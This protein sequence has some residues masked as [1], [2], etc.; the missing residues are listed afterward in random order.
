MNSPG[1]RTEIIHSDPR[2]IR[3]P[4]IPIEAADRVCETDLR[5]LFWGS[6]NIRSIAT[7]PVRSPAGSPGNSNTDADEGPHQKKFDAEIVKA[8]QPLGDQVHFIQSSRTGKNA[9]DFH[10]AFSL[11]Q[12]HQ[13]NLTAKDAARYIVV[14]GDGGFESL[15]EHM[16]RLGCRVGKASSISE[17]CALAGKQQPESPPTPGLSGSVPSPLAAVAPAGKPPAP[18]VKGPPVPSAKAGTRSGT[19]AAAPSSKALRKT[20]AADDVTKVL[21]YMRT[22]AKNR[23]AKRNT[24]ERH[25]ISV[26]GNGV[27]VEVGRAV[28]DELERLNV[29]R[30]SGNKIEYTIPKTKK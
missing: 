10:I 28:V 19:S 24:L 26:L 3:R 1:A 27:T 30:F 6:W 18:A 7:D 20:L 12:L 2:G 25:V 13:M 23:P 22:H 21:D 8:W 29:V 9:L 17:A 5:R 15:L 11:G 16:R 4:W 14:S